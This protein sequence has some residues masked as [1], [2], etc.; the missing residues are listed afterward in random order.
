M[1]LRVKMPSWPVRQMLSIK[2]LFFFVCF[3]LFLVWP[4]VVRFYTEGHTGGG[5]F[6]SGLEEQVCK[7]NLGRFHPPPHPWQCDW[8][9][10]WL[11]EIIGEAH[12]WQEL[13]LLLL[14]L[15]SLYCPVTALAFTSQQPLHCMAHVQT[16]PFFLFIFLFLNIIFLSPVL[17][18]NHISF[19]IDRLFV[20]YFDAIVSVPCQAF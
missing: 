11:L 13:L 2:T 1:R 20:S 6:L 12:I 17:V 16:V 8:S 3:F 19:S 4:A 10:S 18:H 5:F 9:V 15:L 14:L 7:L